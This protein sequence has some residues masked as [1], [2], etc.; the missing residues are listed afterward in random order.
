ML[1]L[2]QAHQVILYSTCLQ[3]ETYK[4]LLFKETAFLDHQ[5][6]QDKVGSETVRMFGMETPGRQI[7]SSVKSPHYSL[8]CEAC[9][10]VINGEIH[11]VFG[12]PAG[13]DL[14]SLECE[15]SICLILQNPFVILTVRERRRSQTV[16]TSLSSLSSAVALHPQSALVLQPPQLRLSLLQL[17]LQKL[18]LLLRGEKKSS[19]SDSHHLY[20]VFIIHC[21]F[22][23]STIFYSHL[24]LAV[25]LYTISSTRVYFTDF[26]T[27][28][29]MLICILLSQYS[30]QILCI[31][32]K[33]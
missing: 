12:K 32:I 11:Y 7:R 13:G 2:W 15:M 31:N 3:A 28:G 18:Q 21:W 30:I 33:R 29:Y 22:N 27:S 8:D 1:Y 6:G 16:P 25:Y 17:P 4:R 10:E 14:V 5:R 19:I 26:C 24:P 9:E 23:I 20:C